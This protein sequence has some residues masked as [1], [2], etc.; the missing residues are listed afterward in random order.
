[1]KRVPFMKKVHVPTISLIRNYPKKN[2]HT[3]SVTD[4]RKYFRETRSKLSTKDCLQI[5]GKY[6]HNAMN[7]TT[8]VM[9]ET[10]KVKSEVCTGGF[11]VVDPNIQYFPN[12][13]IRN[14][15]NIQHKDKSIQQ[16]LILSINQN[17]L[18]VFSY[19]T[20]PFNENRIFCL[21]AITGFE[22]IDKNNN[23]PTT[24]IPGDLTHIEYNIN[25]DAVNV[26]NSNTVTI[27]GYSDQ[28]K[29]SSTQD[30]ILKLEKKLAVS[31]ITK[32]NEDVVTILF[33]DNNYEERYRPC[34]QQ[35]IDEFN[36]MYDNGH[37]SFYGA[38]I[39][40]RQSA[41]R[42]NNTNSIFDKMSDI[43]E[44]SHIVQ[45]TISI[46]HIIEELST[47]EQSYQKRKHVRLGYY[48]TLQNDVIILSVFI[49]SSLKYKIT[50]IEPTD[51]LG[52]FTIDSFYP[53]CLE[54]L[55][56]KRVFEEYNNLGPNE[57]FSI[58]GSF[59]I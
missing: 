53:Q 13:K 41:I 19:L 59:I 37:M 27:D 34:Y 52:V 31:V 47:L 7:N 9:I 16:S 29:K 46:E 4:L 24:T 25:P 40:H 5:P 20:G 57:S 18:I 55:F 39:T 33:D 42:K 11:V 30:I 54:Q 21:Y 26:I 43:Y 28:T 36:N 12:I 22:Y 3:K 17:Q 10:L 6:K 1:M 14:K 49:I 48:S 23:S 15:I 50:D 8:Y 56:D 38:Q 32:N 51:V 58:Y 2:N 44:Q 35:V 45:K